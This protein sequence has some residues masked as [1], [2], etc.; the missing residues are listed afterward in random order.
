MGCVMHLHT[1]VTV[2]PGEDLTTDEDHDEDEDSPTEDGVFFDCVPHDH[3]CRAFANQPGVTDDAR[4]P[5]SNADDHGEA[6]RIDIAN[7]PIWWLPLPIR[8]DHHP[9]FPVVSLRPTQK[10]D[11]CFPMGHIVDRPLAE[12]SSSSRPSAVYAATGFLAT[13]DAM[14]STTTDTTSTTNTTTSTTTTITDSYVQIGAEKTTT[15][16]DVADDGAETTGRNNTLSLAEQV[17][18]IIP[19]PTDAAEDSWNALG[20][21][22]NLC[23]DDPAANG[24]QHDC[25]NS[26]ASRMETTSS[27]TIDAQAADDEHCCAKSCSSTEELDGETYQRLSKVKLLGAPFTYPHIPI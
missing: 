3:L 14:S 11:G 23:M 18:P 25:E 17:P 22:E 20:L 27:S 7:S 5:W 21:H 19:A 16:T 15:T 12:N 8:D 10:F 9:L 24:L 2:Y 26:V 4:S 1:S 13:T 6:H